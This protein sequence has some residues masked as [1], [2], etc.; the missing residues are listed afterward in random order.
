MRDTTQCHRSNKVS[1]TQSKASSCKQAS[2]TSARDHCKDKKKI[3]LDAPLNETLQ[4]KKKKDWTIIELRI[5]HFRREVIINWFWFPDTNRWSIR[6][7]R[8]LLNSI[9]VFIITRARR[10][11]SLGLWGKKFCSRI[12]VVAVHLVL[13]NR[14][15]ARRKWLH[16]CSQVFAT[17][18]KIMKKNI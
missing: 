16:F 10:L 9:K 15:G 8:A 13:I 3:L 17:W 2:M 5:G 11:V 18:M 12:P 1:I 7:I 14:C 6:R 4:K